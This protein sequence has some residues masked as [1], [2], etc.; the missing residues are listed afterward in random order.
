MTGKNYIYHLIGFVIIL[1][2]NIPSYKMVLGSNTHGYL[3]TDDEWK[4]AAE[5][6]ID[7]LRKSDM[8]IRVFDNN[9]NPIPNAKV[10]VTMTRHEFGFGALIGQNRWN[11]RP[12]AADAQRSLKLIDDYF[13]KIVT[14][15]EKNQ[16]GDLML[17][18]L[19]ERDVKVRGHY[20]MWARIQ[21]GERSG[22]PTVMPE[23]PEVLR[24][25]AFQYIEEMVTWA[26][27]RITEWDAINHIVT[28]ISG[29]LGFNHLFGEDFFA[30]VIKH[31]RQF[32]P[33]GVEMW[34][35]EG[36]ILPGDGSRQDKY[37][38]AIQ[39]LIQY[40]G[41]PDGVGFMSHFKRESDLVSMEEI[42][43]RLDRF[44][45]LIPNLQLTEFD[46][47]VESPQLQADYLRD[48][49][50]L[51]FSHPAVTSV[52]MWQV[53]G[54]SP[55]NTTLW[56]PDWSI[57]PAGEAW[58]DL[59]HNHWWTDQTGVTNNDGIFEVRGFLGDYIL[60]IS[61]GDKT[62]IVKSKLVS[63]GTGVDI[64]LSP[65]STANR[66]LQPPVAVRTYPIPFNDHVTIEIASE[67]PTSVSLNVFDITGAKVLVR[68]E[69]LHQGINSISLN[70]GSVPA[71]IY[72]YQIQDI[73]GNVG[74]GTFV[75]KIIKR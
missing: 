5:Y 29:H 53:W 38:D 31:A 17:N 19:K 63:E 3:K 22:Q 71:G 9:G 39:K 59:V 13:N 57:K 72:F 44:A 65:L 21:P 16:T 47:D 45:Q 35:N 68:T 25:M 2:F 37:L 27:D 49:M 6:R 42:Y 20:L 10:D 43:R 28:D 61:H 46:I 33:P 11:N 73:S 26:G 14:I 69:R 23:D 18:W 55:N 7:T 56:N 58:I 24:E 64:H 70:L 74:E 52:V 41:A 30:N 36:G 4:G 50:T 75:G 8:V 60:T 1:F 51:T 66:Y 67:M 54:G 62:Q 34:V 12:N 48:I 32:A 40:G 15:V